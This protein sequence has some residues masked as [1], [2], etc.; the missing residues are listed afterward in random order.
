M[1]ATNT[2]ADMARQASGMLSARRS[3]T[4]APRRPRSAPGTTTPANAAR[5]SATSRVA[6]T[7]VRR[8]SWRS[9]SSTTSQGEQSSSG[10]PYSGGG[11]FLVFVRRA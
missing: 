1:S 11:G 4:T 7:S 6:R 3:P 9:L 5:T 2:V 10:V 8:S